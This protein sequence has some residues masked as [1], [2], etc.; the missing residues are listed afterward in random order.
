MSAANL[1]RLSKVPQIVRLMPNIAVEI[2]AGCTG[3]FT[4]DTTAAN[5]VSVARDWDWEQILQNSGRVI[6]CH[7]ER[8]LDLLSIAAGSG[9]AFFLAFVQSQL[10]FFQQEQMDMAI[11]Q[12]AVAASMMGAAQ[13]LLAHEQRHISQLITNVTSKGGITAAA[14]ECWQR[15][16]MDVITK[17]GLQAAWARL[18]QLN[19]PGDVP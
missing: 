9:P 16:A 12:E 17:Q 7:S 15:Q 1:H 6:R 18:Q 5:G 2:N 11:A 19:Y 4:L 8:D 13:L 10:S 3:I 14:L